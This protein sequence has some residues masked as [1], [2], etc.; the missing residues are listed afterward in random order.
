[1]PVIAGAA[2]SSAPRGLRS[3]LELTMDAVHQAFRDAG[4]ADAPPPVDIVGV[5]RLAADSVPGGRSA[6]FAGA[7]ARA[8]PTS[9]SR[10]V[11]YAEAG[12]HTTQAL[13]S[14]LCKDIDAGRATLA[15]VVG[16]DA[17]SPFEGD[18]VDDAM[19][20]DRGPSLAGVVTR[21][22]GDHR[23]MSACHV[24][25]LIADARCRRAKGQPEPRLEGRPATQS[26]PTPHAGDGDATTDGS[27][28]VDRA[29]ALV[30][31]SAAAA[32]E[33]G[34][35]AH[36]LVHLHGAAEA[37]DHGWLQRQRLDDSRAV[38]R[39]CAQALYAAGLQARELDGLYV[40]TPFP[41]YAWPACDALGFGSDGRTPTISASSPHDAPDP[42]DALQGFVQMV[43][44]LRANPG[45]LAALVAPGHAMARCAA[46]VWS[47]RLPR[48]E[49]RDPPPLP[50]PG[51]MPPVPTVHYADGHG[52]LEAAAVLDGDPAVVVAVGLRDRGGERFVA[53]SDER[54]EQVVAR[55]RGGTL[56]DVQVRGFG[57]GNR[58]ATDAARLVALYPPR[59]GAWRDAYRYCNVRRDGH[60]LEVTIARPELRNCLHPP[61]S[62]EL[63]EIFDA[64]AADD[65][66]WVA[67]LTGAGTQAFCAGNDLKYAAGHRVYVPRNG[68]GGMTWR[69]NLDKPVI[70]AVN[71]FAFGGGMELAMACDLVVAD[72]TASFALTEVRLGMLAS[73]SGLVRLPRR[74]PPKVAT[75]LVLTGRRMG[76]EE[77]QRLGLVNRLAPAGAAPTAARALAAEML[78]AS[79]RSVRSSLRI[80]REAAA[81]A[82][83]RQAL[84]HPY[85]D[86]EVNYWS[87]DRA[88]GMRAFAEKRPPAWKN[89]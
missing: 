69:T 12:G 63:D 28:P 59:T 84:L 38:H 57:F 71:G 86:L 60:V 25:A 29:A 79:P 26:D 5:L 11:I 18:A 33:L 44:G 43:R 34:L 32:A 64:Y 55:C 68:F 13:V 85:E 31:M 83:E 66:L 40:A 41:A 2:S 76:A 61:A 10:W 73:G 35:D 24:H 46:G 74:I 37:G 45:S 6:A 62:E 87:A 49:L 75:E 82:D 89:R 16:A 50:E 80:M 58:F 53:L 21:W 48:A 81:F 77:A 27:E 30:L 52:T 47:T 78:Q 19:V 22:M 72:A 14:S 3:P 7:V 65:D 42:H 23:L 8:L 17:A 54:D 1:M 67:I 56:T 4:L 70:A 20:E 88:E 36:R 51:I 15:V 9:P 39:A